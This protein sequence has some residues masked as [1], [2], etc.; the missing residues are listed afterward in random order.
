MKRSLVRW[1]I[2]IVSYGIVISLVFGGAL[3]PGKGMLLFGDDIHH[4]YYYFR[5]FFNYWLRLGIFPW[6]N[7]YLFGGQPFIADPIVNIWY[8]PNWLF[9]LL[10]INTAYSWH[11]AFHV[12][13]AM[14][15]MYVLS[16]QVTGNSLPLTK[17][18]NE[19]NLAAW[20]SGLVFGLS[21]FFMART[22]AGH[23]DVIAAASWM[24]WVAWAFYRLITS[25]EKF[26]S[27]GASRR[28]ALASFVFAMQLFAGYQTMAF[29]TV[30]IVGLM[31][32]VV[33][34]IRRSFIPVIC[35]MAAG[36]LGLGLAA[37]QILPEQEFFRS[38]IRTYSFPYSWISYGS[39]TW[40][41]LMQFLNPFF[42]G[43]QHTYIGPPPNFIEHSVFVGI[44]GLL[45]A[46]IGGVRIVRRL[47]G[48]HRVIKE[49]NPDMFAGMVFIFI[50]I[51]GI[52]M[53]LGPNA[54][55]DLQ[56]F[57]WKFLPMYKYLRI[58]TR[59]LI[60][61]VFGLAGL[62]GIGLSAVRPKVIQIILAVCVVGE[63]M[64]FGRGFIE[65][66][67][68]P[69]AR[70]DQALI[71]LLKKDT[72]PYRVLQDFGVWLPQRDAL[73]FDGVMSYEI[74]SATGYDPSILRRYYDFM[75]RSA[76]MASD[77]AI[78]LQDVQVPYLTPQ[79]PEALDFLNIKYII[80]P[81]EYDPFAGNSRYLPVMVNTA[82][83]FHVYQNQ[84]VQP[85][86]FLANPACGTP[87][88]TS[89]TPNTVR[90]SLTSSCNSELNSSE[91]WYP[92]WHA[93][94]DGKEVPINKLNGTFR[95][96]Y[97]LPGN[98]VIIYEYRPKIFLIGG[99]ISVISILLLFWFAFGSQG[100]TVWR[101]HFSLPGRK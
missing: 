1:G 14:T 2:P 27:P 71:A 66:K 46:I 94:V 83:R 42:F 55:L 22:W 35:A 59:H 89:Y 91:V 24:P 76:M 16:K 44:G 88:V 64:W 41:S 48:G 3:I 80:V 79:S 50:V 12:L 29:F 97:V 58:P 17:R 63:L 56:Y 9:V 93:T 4:Q 74:F 37:L 87:L 100:A 95:T 28:L 57:L 25:R 96:L 69:E 26:F 31:T 65:L 36:V 54:P 62:A 19:F 23:V 32:V 33:S 18:R 5:E 7:P 51:F 49:K 73:D 34:V 40:Q 60:L 38:S 45:L 53:S 43:N 30:Y 47:F 81:M 92:G 13:W 98:H 99:G 39:W 78:L 15:G 21:G 85:R 86:F 11:V 82:A 75:S 77:K 68:V 101:V 52:W 6:W 84:T 70:H 67:P 20:V 72:Q 8:P 10:P 90:I 61:V